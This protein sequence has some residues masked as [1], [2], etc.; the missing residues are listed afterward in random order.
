MLARQVF[1]TSGHLS[2]RIVQHAE[3]LTEVETVR[4]TN[5]VGLLNAAWFHGRQALCNGTGQVKSGKKSSVPHVADTFLC[6]QEGQIGLETLDMCG[7]DEHRILAGAGRVRELLARKPLVE[8]CGEVWG[9]E[10]DSHKA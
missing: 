9:R 6:L 5:I 10:V 8:V 3:H 7:H 1:G 2:L 4:L